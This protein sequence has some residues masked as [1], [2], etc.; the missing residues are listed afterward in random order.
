MPLSYSGGFLETV[1]ELRDYEAAG[2][3]RVL[4]PEAYSFDAVSQL[5]YIAAKTSTVRLVSSILNIYSRS[6]SLLAMTAAGLD[7]VSSGRFIMGLGASGP[8]VVEGFHGI[9]YDAPLARTREVI[10]ICRQVWRREVVEHHG[11]YFDVPLTT[12]RG[13]SGLGKP[14]KLINKPVRPSVPVILAAMGPRNVELA[15]ELFEGWEPLFFVPELAA[16]TFGKSLAA[17]AVRRDRA[18]PPLDITVNTHVLVTEDPQE[19]HAGV[20]AVREHLALYIGGM[21]AQ[22]KNFYHDLAARLGFGT[23]ADRVQTLFLAGDREA[24]QEAVPEGLVHGVALVGDRSHVA[25][26]LRAFRDAGV[27]TLNARPLAATHD[28]RVRDIGVLKELLRVT[29]GAMHA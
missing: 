10:D 29:A 2:L 14:M 11:R 16:E 9:A 3:D 18:L 15:A 28:K 4:L 1:E 26:R 5:G 22:G 25:A 17:G 13:G 21:G 12:E 19:R 27:S 8:Q 24:A 23:E 20:R 7:Y 6:P